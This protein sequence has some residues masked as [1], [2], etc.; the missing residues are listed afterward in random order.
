MRRQ[1]LGACSLLRSHIITPLHLQHIL[2]PPL[3]TTPTSSFLAILQHTDIISGSPVKLEADAAQ[4][5]ES[6]RVMKVQ[7]D[8]VTILDS[9]EEI[10]AAPRPIKLEKQDE[11]RG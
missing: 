11:L 3:H 5:E 7:Y 4:H 6:P 8:I 9:D 1:V 2:L 10:D